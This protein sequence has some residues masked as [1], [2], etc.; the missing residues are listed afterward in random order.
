MKSIKNEIELTKISSP[1]TV[2]EF[3]I[4]N[5]NFKKI[6]L[7]L[8]IKEEIS[9]EVLP[10]LNKKDS[11]ELGLKLG[12]WK[13]IEK[14]IAENKG[15]LLKDQ[16]SIAYNEI[17]INMNS[18]INAIKLFFENY[19]NFKD[20]NN[21]FDIDGK[22]LF[23][24][25]EQDMK[26]L[27]LTLGKRK[28]LNL[29]LQYIQKKANNYEISINE[30]STSKDVA[31]FLKYK[32]NMPQNV[33]EDMALDGESLTLIKEEDIDE[34]EEIPE[35]IKNEF[36]NYIKE[37]NMEKINENNKKEKEIETKKET[38]ENNFS[39]KNR[40]NNIEENEVEDLPTEGKNNNSG[41][42][43]EIIK[44]KNN[45]YSIFNFELKDDKNEKKT[46]E[47][48]KDNMI[49]ELLSF[50]TNINQEN[51]NNK[52]EINL[53]DEDDTIQ[54]N[55]DEKR[56]EEEIHKE[57]EEENKI[58]NIENNDVDNKEKKI[59]NNLIKKSL[60]KEY[61]GEEMP[62]IKT[63]TINN[64]KIRKIIDD[65]K[66]NLFFFLVV[67]DNFMDKINI[68]IVS[69]G[70]NIHFKY[71]FIYEYKKLI[72][73]GVL[74]FILVQIHIKKDIDK[75]TII[76]E[77]NIKRIQE[78]IEFEKI[79]E[80]SNVFYLNKIVYPTINKNDF[81]I[82]ELIAQYFN[83][84][85]YEHNIIDERFK[86][87]FIKLLSQEKIL[88][89][90]EE[91]YFKFI[92]YCL[93]F[94]IKPRYFE[95]ISI[96][97][98]DKKQIKS[99][100]IFYFN[101]WKKNSEFNLNEIEQLIAYLIKEYSKYDK[102]FINEMFV[103]SKYWNDYSIAIFNSLVQK[104]LEINQINF[105]E[106][107]DRFILQNSLLQISEAFLDI[108]LIIK[109]S[110]NLTNSCK[111]IINNFKKI[112]KILNDDPNFKIGK[113]TFIPLCNL[114]ENDN[115]NDIY[116]LIPNLIAINNSE[117]FKKVIDFEKL[118]NNLI[119]FYYN[120]TL[121]EFFELKKV[122]ELLR[123]N[124][125]IDNIDVENYYKRL[126]FKGIILINNKKLEIDDII[127]FLY[128]QDVYYYDIK[129]KRDNQRDPLIFKYIDI[130]NK[131]ENYLINIKKLKENKIWELFQ[132]STE[133]QKLKFYDSFLFQIQ[134]FADFKNIFELFPIEVINFDFL[135]LISKKLSD[136]LFYIYKE[137]KEN[138]LNIFLVLINYYECCENHNVNNKTFELNKLD[139]NFV[140]EFYFYILNNKK[141]RI[142]N[143][144][145]SEIMSFFFE[146]NVN[147]LNKKIIIKLI[148]LSSF[149][150]FYIDILNKIELFA[151]KEKDFYTKEKNENFELFTL[152]FKKCRE[153]IDKNKIT[154]GKYL[155][156]SLEIK[157]KIK[158]DLSNN[159]I[160]YELI[161]NLID[162]DKIFYNKILVIFDN[163]KEN[164]DEVYN[165]LK[166]NL[167]KCETKLNKFR[168]IEEFYNTFYKISKRQI[169]D[170]INLNLENINQK[171]L[172]AIL[173]LD[174][175]E[176]IKSSNFNFNNAL[177]ESENI[178]Y[179]RSLFFMAIYN[180]NSTE[181]LDKNE[182]NIFTESK[183]NFK[184]TMH[185][186]I[187]QKET[188]EP[189]FEI[190]NINEIMKVTRDQNNNLKNDIEIILEEFN[191]L[192]MNDYIN[193]YLLEDL[194][195]FSKKEK[196]QNVIEG[197]YS[198]NNSFCKIA[199]FEVTR[200][201]NDLL[202]MIKKLNLN[203]VSADDIKEAISLLSKLNIKISEETALMK[204]YI[205]FL[206]K[207][208]SIEFIKDIKKSNL[209]IRNLNE[210]IDENEN[211]QI[212]INDIDNLLD[213]YTFFR[214]FLEN[215]EIKTDNDFYDEFKKEFE[216]DNNIGIKLQEYL[217]SYGEIYQLYQLY[218]ENSEMT[219]QKI[220]NILKNS[221]LE[222]Y[223]Q[224]DENDLFIYKIQ[225]FN[226]K[227]KK[228]EINSNDID[229]LKNKI[230]I[231]STKNTNIIHDEGN[232][233]VINKEELT[234]KFVDLIENIQQLTKFL[235]QLIESGYPFLDNFILQINDSEAFKKGNREMK[236]KNIMENYDEENR[237]YKDK[238]N[239]GYINF[240][241]LRLFYGKKFIKL[242]LKITKN[243]NIDI[244]H[245]V[246]SMSLNRIHN[247]NIDFEYNNNKDNIENINEYLNLLFT[248]NK[249]KLEDIYEQN[250]ILNN[251]DLSP[252]L[253]KIEKN[254]KNF[255][256]NTN[257]ISL[258]FNLTGKAPLINT[259]LI[260]NEETN[261]E[262]IKA[263]FFR[264]IFCE[265]NSL[266]L[267]TNLECLPLSITHE[268]I[269][270]L[271]A[272][273]SHKKRMINSLLIIL[274]EKDD[275]G[276]S[277]DI[278]K[279]IPDKYDFI[280]TY[281]KPSKKI[282]LFKDIEVYT[283]K[284]AGYGK[285][286]EIKYFVKYTG[287]LYHYFPIGGTL[288]RN[289]VINN[290]EKL[291][292]NLSN[293][294]NIYLH[295]DLSEV[296][297]DKIMDEILIKLLILRYIDSYDKIYY[298]G[299]NVHIIVELPKGFIDFKEKYQILKLFK[300]INIDKLRPLRLEENIKLVKDSPISIVAETLAL[301]DKNDYNNNV[302]LN[303]PIR[304]TA[305][306]CEQLINKYFKVNNQNYYQ[307]I[308]FIKILSI[309]FKKFHEN[310]YFNLDIIDP[311]RK[312]IVRTARRTVLHNF[313]SL[314][315]V[316]TQSPYD[317]IL[318]EQIEAL[319]KYGKYDENQLKE[320]AIKSL[321]NNK[322]EIFSFQQINP[323]LVFFNKDGQALSIITNCEKNKDE[324]KNLKALW[325]SQ[326]M[327][328]DNQEELVQYKE[329]SHE[330]FLEQIIKLFSL[331]NKTV[332]DLK[333]F[334]EEHG[335]Y[336]FVSDN[337]I[338]MVRILLNIEAKIP[339][340]LMGETGVGK[341]KLIE[342]LSE[343]YGNGTCIWKTLQIHAGITDQEI[344][345]F[346]DKIKL[347]ENQKENKD[348]LIWVFFDEINTCNSL[349]LIAEI[350]CNHTYLGQKIS[351]NFIFIGA[352]NPYRI[353]TKKMKETGLVYYNMKEKNKLN[354]LVY[355]V[356]PLPHSLLNFVFD[357][358]NLQQKDEE[359]YINNTILSMITKMQNQN[360]ISNQNDKKKEK[361]VRNMIQSIIICHE[362]IR[363]LYD[364][365]SVSMR[366]IRRFGILF[367]YFVKYFA[368]IEN[369]AKKMSASLNLSLF[370][371]YYLRLNDKTDRKNLA[372]KLEKFFNNNFLSLPEKIMKEITEKMS[373][374]KN[375]GIALNRALRENLFSIYIC[376][377]NT[378][379]LIII[380]K[381][382]TSKSLSFQILYNTMK[383]QYSENRYFKDKGKLYRYYYQGSETSTSKGIEQVFSKAL[384]AQIKNKNKN[385][386]TLVFFDEMGLAER[387]NNNPLKV[388]HYLLEKDAENSVPFLG[389][390]NWRL[391]ASKIN[392]VLNLAITDYDIED[393]EE[394]A[395][396][397]ADA[398]NNEIRTKY[399]EFFETLAR[400]YN[401]YIILNQELRENK[402]FHGNRDFYNLIKNS[403][404]ELIKLSNENVKLEKNEKKILT[405]VGIKCLEINFGGLEYSTKKIKEIFKKEYSHH[406]FFNYDINKNI[407]IIEIIKSNICDSNR[408]YLMLI[409]DG[410]DASD[411]IKYILNSLKKDYI[412]IVGSKYKQDITSGKYSE[413]ILNKIKYIMESDNILILRDLDMI[414]ASLY[415]IFNQN[416]TCMGDKKFARIA[417]EYAKISSE[418]N[419]DFRVIIIVNKEK[420]EELKLD[421]PFLNRFE[422]HIINFK[423]ILNEKDI[424]ISKNISKYIE[425]ISGV[426]NNKLNLNLSKL[427][428]NC[429]E[430]NIDGLICK[431]KNDQKINID[432]PKYE[433]IIIENVLE[434]IVPTFCQ[435]VIAYLMTKKINIEFH[436]INDRVINLYQKSRFFNFSSFFEN[437]Q[438]K[439]NV[440][441]TFS[442]ITEDI[443]YEEKDLK[444]KF[445]IFNNHSMEIVIIESIKSEN[446]L[447]FLL[448]NFAYNNK[449]A[450]LILK[451]S[452]KELNQMNTINFVISKYEKDNI[453][454]KEKIIIFTV[455]KQRK[456]KNENKKANKKEVQPDYIS[457]M[458]DEYYQIFI[459][460]LQ[461]KEKYN[462]FNILSEKTEF[463]AK[464]YIIESNFIDNKIYIILNYL[465]INIRNSKKEFNEK[466]CN[467]IIAEN[468]IGNE[469]LKNLI[470][471]SLEIQGKKI[472]EIINDVFTSKSIEM[473][474]VDFYEV[475]NSKFNNYFSEYLLN[476]II[477]SLKRYI[478][479]P[480]L[481]Q[482]NLDNFLNNQ[483]FNN[484]LKIQFEKDKFNI[485]PK[486][487]QQINSNRIIIYYGFILPH[488]K[489]SL[490]NIVNYIKEE[491]SERYLNNEESLRERN[492]G[493]KNFK[494]L[495]EKYNDE[496]DRIKENVKVEINKEE[497]F[498]TLYNQNNEEFKEFL[499]KDYLNYFIIKYLEKN[500]AN[501]QNIEKIY[502]FLLLLLILKL[503]GNKISTISFENTIDEFIEIL[504]FTQGYI[505]DINILFDAF[506]DLERYCKNI[507]NKIYEIICKNI[508]KYEI[509]D[510]ND[511]F[512]KIVNLHWFLIIESITR[513]ML[514]NSIDLFNQDR[515]K[516]YD[517]F[518]IFPSLET[519]FQK[520]NKKYYLYNKE[521]FNLDTIVKINESYKYSIDK[522]EKYYKDIVTNLLE[523]T[524]NLYNNNYYDY[525][526]TTK[527]LNKIINASFKIKTEEYINL[528]FFIFLQQY[529]VILDEETKIKLI[530][531]FFKDNLLI[532]KSK[533]LLVE[534]LKDTKP[535]ISKYEDDF[536]NYEDNP[537]L[538][539]YKKLYEIYNN[540]KS[541]EFD[542]LLLFTFENLCQSYF[543][544]ILD[545]NE[546]K[547]T[548]N[549]CK[550]ILL[551]YS[552]N[553]FKK[554]QLYLYEHK[555]NFD[556]LLKFN[557]IAYI[558]MYI[559]YFVN[560]N[561]H[562]NS[563]CDFDSINKALDDENKNNKPL[564]NVRN[565]YL[566]R[567]YLNKFE[568]FEQFL[569]LNYKKYKI[570]I[571]KELID[572][573]EEEKNNNQYIFKESF[574]FI[575]NFDK[576][577]K[578]Q[579]ELES[580]NKNFA[581]NFDEISHNFDFF[582]C[583]LVNKVLSNLYNNNNKRYIEKLKNIYK[584]T[585]DEINLEKEVSIL[586]QYFMN[587]DIFE[588]NIISK[589]C[590]ER[591]KQEDFEILLYSFRFI[592]KILSNQNSSFY[593]KMILKNTNN[594]LENNF[595]PGNFP[596]INE[597]IKSYNNLVEFFTNYQQIGY[598]ICADCGFLYQ[599]Q[600]CTYPMEESKCPNG[601]IIG[602]K[603]HE[604]SKKDIRVF[605]NAEIKGKFSQASFI[606]QT[607]D[608]FKMNY[609]DKYINYMEKG[610]MKG[611][612]KIDFESDKYVT[613]IN[614]ITYR[615]LNFILYS[616]LLASYVLGNISKRE[617]QLYLIEDLVPNNL[618]SVIKEGWK[619]LNEKLKIVGIENAKIFFNIIFDEL[620]EFIININLI[621]TKNKL[622]EFEKRVNDFILEKITKNSAKK[623]NE[624]YQR[625]N[626]ELL[627]L[628]PNNIKEVILG[629]YD[630]NA[631]SKETYPDI[632]YYFI[633][634]LN[635]I[636]TF[637]KIFNSSN[638][639]K[640]K[641]SLI[642]I[643]VNG[644][645][646]FMKNILKMKNLIYINKLSNLLIKI[647]SYK[648][649]R[650][651]AK[652]RK[653]KDE[654][655]SI[656]EVLN[657]TS[658][659][660]ITKNIFIQEYVEPFLESWNNIKSD[661]VQ[662]MCRQ[663]RNIERGEKP[664]NLTVDNKLCYF[665]VDD[666]DK[667]GGMFLAS[668][669]ENFIQWQNQFIDDIIAKNNLGGILNSYVSQLEIEI[670]VQDAEENEIINIDE[671]TYYNLEELI[672][673]YSMRNI[674]DINDKQIYYKN[675]ND[676][677]YN[678]DLIEEKLAKLIL[679][680]IKK[681]K[682][683]KYKFITYLYEGFRGQNSTVL[684][685]YNDKYTKCELTEEEKNYINKS[686]KN[687]NN[688]NKIYNYIFDIK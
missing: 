666:G 414:Y 137:S 129:Y 447:I 617:L 296:D 142:L 487:K 552:L 344:I 477:D 504:L 85:F 154:K 446:D 453:L 456:L 604:C 187:K 570:P 30:K 628:N 289:F 131:N 560:I 444:N 623:I 263:F 109:L 669:Y 640:R 376:I 620:T 571:I 43:K 430:H 49:E 401:K 582:Y 426:K 128:K 29:Y 602:G 396:S 119:N 319:N 242:Y 36:K 221:I 627:N 474:D 545:I 233:T 225:Y 464:K 485:I 575:S 268:V 58:Q 16:N 144:L 566:W 26:K 150:D 179:K 383:G 149:N 614:C 580:N 553:Y 232:N 384:N 543:Q 478:L 419:K 579:I 84:F 682:K 38:H 354:N 101:D 657:I 167:K 140:S 667:E 17:N 10:Y 219:T 210:F 207:E 361:V 564:R 565:I 656:I 412:E 52:N 92:K 630:P 121:N 40:D 541:L 652:K 445:G 18:D 93:E 482:K 256:L 366:E 544:D 63:S 25:S 561:Y 591:L 527:E 546:G 583:A 213:V 429:E 203:T 686:L 442:K 557:S 458:N 431:I 275:S 184:N 102:K 20:V 367:E 601:H 494:F 499:L 437:L 418:I 382:G 224:N 333:K 6:D 434:K 639:N 272:L 188:K 76:I 171:T 385:I 325:N 226:Y 531:D 422:K 373:I 55:K 612:R 33:I 166:V 468:I 523:Q 556:K 228:I 164:T 48:E 125:V 590:D 5:F 341:T 8:F 663:L 146:L 619:L 253:Y 551:E 50:D 592:F 593:K 402:D 473:N 199:N 632:Q 488:C 320:N 380:G 411:I 39:Y 98:E 138:F 526:E 304:K 54:I 405:E 670:N 297:N 415:D 321:A 21:N 66:Y 94:N 645:L 389:I 497:F 629:S 342:V 160:H 326:N 625:L 87:D 302:N 490:D 189:F 465:Q 259:L 47:K 410:S 237:K 463:L 34:I 95:K 584:E 659:K 143:R 607:L 484:L 339:V 654:I 327:N 251:L 197:I 577:K 22:K 469:K 425:E 148:L 372:K 358:G 260:C 158:N 573:L 518:R 673:F 79:Q 658:T 550:Q 509:S 576:F 374:E 397:I 665:L 618:F 186:I 67:N 338:K 624:E 216:K 512:S 635:N 524:S 540:I 192:N 292:L 534:T 170:S 78:D 424:E 277:K 572:K 136:L 674:F 555:N 90:T 202:Q 337:Y 636:D 416:F 501:Y 399:K 508:I 334:C 486:P 516:F 185:K 394:T 476:I 312:E 217:N 261:L 88:E 378:I 559:Y 542:E 391:D 324:Y 596:Y 638:E 517:F 435:D 7:I 97:K 169:I 594:I 279:L 252:G 86:I 428:I 662:Y 369:M 440:I 409:S 648:I 156:K 163:D 535:Q 675:Y 254:T 215:N 300:S 309:Q 77:E 533:L 310:I 281:L 107:K 483:S 519:N 631:Y 671:N 247:F 510:R 569:N 433:N 73:P 332:E 201:N 285:T 362:Y 677:K 222:I 404:R 427:L 647:Y 460:N 91:I 521:I 511:E 19:L 343:L 241:L 375:A 360:I 273:Y 587:Y 306:E 381:P 568:N 530:E 600:N 495:I 204:F 393:L 467:A 574:I 141:S 139:Y 100:D 370:L 423:M 198:F 313:I 506:L 606:S 235:N 46:N 340:I 503:K 57:K 472:K 589:I 110:I 655:K 513:A 276:L 240:P 106:E 500:G 633:S 191:D 449:K 660:K 162:E 672:R 323:S 81:N 316:F 118:Y 329:L 407:N 653:F 64:Y 220:S 298:L 82:N 679:P 132:E 287:G 634:D 290:L 176:F 12:H 644:N 668:A 249:C 123:S 96:I 265:Y 610:I 120:K 44:I 335:N 678:Y 643:L 105:I 471:K 588:K 15:K 685:Q 683:N 438:Y 200:F 182:H 661:L 642:N 681:F 151:I 308:N 481:N 62:Y 455:H 229:E 284:F 522:F 379:P 283:S 133:G 14:F 245:L 349:G 502:N 622:E 395:L 190:P 314:T 554:A 475:I 489:L 346:I 114:N 603:N 174:E 23:S 89:M 274:Y 211:N 515:N 32:F 595:I 152:F 528:R 173:N 257:I 175:N 364:R 165:N 605:P 454:L 280:S 147:K 492:K 53:I 51:E 688:D 183:N 355:T 532:K 413:E 68:A 359:K 11:K 581:F 462:I 28:K 99:T 116:E 13:K 549:S 398:L 37:I 598:Y 330:G 352:C 155:F 35:E 168:I 538:N 126:H 451:I 124:N 56:E 31:T 115:I 348:K 282:N 311:Q 196:L 214:K 267:I 608:E 59:E 243:K 172:S 548:K 24:M 157:N 466:N 255:D 520:L 135:L 271:Y 547:Y 209:E 61:E 181:N 479:I 650:E 609:V 377:T 687:I 432:D 83:Y 347:E 205:I 294:K 539:K 459:D 498:N 3:F 317:S 239:N 363:D 357:F 2:V 177:K 443:L 208:D 286:T 651:D 403:V 480:I 134:T 218:D 45:D 72:N 353:I 41:N 616:C 1:E 236:L 611:Y 496:L 4:Q 529:K 505:Q 244:S 266:F 299:N 178:K 392:R 231:S 470:F 75:L 113:D 621:D 421:P 112:Q 507:K 195:N 80:N 307:K 436:N 371:C 315:K 104:T 206:G 130:T 356:N 420:I 269:K 328:L 223:K 457:F 193:N 514:I 153:I 9:G 230:L 303:M 108:K 295:L 599:V 578:I 441:Y 626:S 301:I 71:N 159:N 452:E 145:K 450:V 641:Y 350:M 406:F 322:K 111:F 613:E 388:M 649:S 408:R 386:I 227:N 637:S 250:R 365:S 684:T 493:K 161:N 390:S 351:D 74:N 278:R 345:D 127:N 42:V 258:F 103:Q 585:K 117:M 680:G 368:N 536:L 387:S 122:I 331:N 293:N 194:I 525:Y 27:G 234:N 646:D 318:S 69:S 567:V 65:S 537:K 563:L 248:K 491:I 291:N 664:L 615:I 262:E 180:K 586:Y 676:I 270:I 461:G 597:F 238:I 400:V 288:S 439:K 246:N 417:F 212:Q 448:K 305:A 60:L 70:T 336:I 264:A 562:Q 558:K